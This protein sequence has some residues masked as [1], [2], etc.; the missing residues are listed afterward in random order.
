M[1]T[2]CYAERPG[3]DRSVERHWLKWTLKVILLNIEVGV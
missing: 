1:N 2:K 3:T